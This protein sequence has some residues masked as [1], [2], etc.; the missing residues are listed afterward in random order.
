M[1]TRWGVR[2]T[3]LQT[4]ERLAPSQ[5]APAHTYGTPKGQWVVGTWAEY[6]DPMK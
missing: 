5:L 3:E 1:P 6:S 4:Y 2:V